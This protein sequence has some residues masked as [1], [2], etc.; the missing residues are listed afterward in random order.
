MI[1]FRPDDLMTPTTV[2]ASRRTAYI[3]LTLMAVC[4]GG[5]W[6]A[7]KVAVAA[8]S[9]F[10]LAAT[11]FVIASALL[12]GWARRTPIHGRRPG[13]TDLP[14]VLGMGLTAVAGYNVLFL[15]GLRLAPASDGAIIVPGL[16]PVLTTVLAWPLLQERIGRLGGAGLGAALAGLILVL[17]PSGGH[18]TERFSGDALFFLGACCWAI[19]TIIGKAAT[20]R[21]GAVRATLY[22]TITGTLILLPF[23][24]A[25]RGWIKLAAAPIVGWAGL[26]YLA[27]FGTVLPFVFLYEGIRR[28]GASRAAAFAFL[29]PIIG[30][31]SSVLILG[32]A[33]SAPTVVGG[34]FV[35][36]GL[37]LV[38]RQP[39]LAAAPESATAPPP[40]QGMKTGP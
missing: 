37:W 5:T 22:G 36:L 14:M 2:A 3:L 21:F 33:L 18:G 31:G 32:E 23:A 27:I 39:L 1:Y 15:Y 28:I 26:A 9:P 10:T 40:A 29:I 25:E 13:V 34:A 6:V 30:V 16:A 8:I 38:Q 17:S 35:L 12:W 4:F 7:G 20:A 11:R 24:A 19:Y